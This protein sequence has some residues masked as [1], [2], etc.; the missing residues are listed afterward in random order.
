V[1]HWTHSI[2]RC[3]NTLCHFM[4]NF[5]N[6]THNSSNCTDNFCHPT[7]NLWDFIQF[8]CG[9]MCNFCHFARNDCFPPCRKAPGSF[10]TQYSP[11]SN[12]LLSQNIGAQRSY[13]DFQSWFLSFGSCF[14]SMDIVIDL[15]LN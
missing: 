1:V 9:F 8:F 15:C 6:F 13:P 14:P 11:D 5:C 4:T 10:T 12:N 2:H 3:I 7:H